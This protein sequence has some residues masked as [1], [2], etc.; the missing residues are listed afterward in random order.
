MYEYSVGEYLIFCINTDQKAPPPVSSEY[1]MF[2][3]YILD[4]WWWG[5]EMR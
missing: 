1:P 5:D 2:A 3:S 4:D